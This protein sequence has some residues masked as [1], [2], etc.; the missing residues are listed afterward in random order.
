MNPRLSTPEDGSVNVERSY[1]RRAV[2][3]L[4]LAEVFIPLVFPSLLSTLM[5]QAADE[6]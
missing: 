3:G 5:R 1:L 2:V 4:T 6:K